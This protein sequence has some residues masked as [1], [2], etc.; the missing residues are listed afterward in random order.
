M[1]P[2][3]TEDQ[4]RLVRIT[5]E[6]TIQVY[7]SDSLTDQQH[8]DRISKGYKSGDASFELGEVKIEFVD[9]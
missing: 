6:T 2:R 1:P 8:L 9:Q 4:V 3:D 7:A 5:T